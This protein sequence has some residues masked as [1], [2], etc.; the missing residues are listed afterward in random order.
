MYIPQILCILC[1]R[2]PFSISL[3]RFVL[4]RCQRS[5]HLALKFYWYLVSYVEDD[6]VNNTYVKT[7]K[8]SCEMALVN[9][10][11]EAS[12]ST[13]DL[14]NVANN[15]MER[16]A[17]FSRVTTLVDNLMRISNQLRSVLPVEE[18]PKALQ[19]KLSQTMQ[20]IEDNGAYI[21]LW[22]ADSR[23][24]SIV[25]LPPGEGVVLNSRDRCPYM[26]FFEVNISQLVCSQT[27]N[28][29]LKSEEIEVLIEKMKQK[30]DEDKLENNEEF[31]SDEEKQKAIE[32][33]VD[34]SP[35][36]PSQPQPE[37]WEE[38]KERIREKSPLAENNP[39]WDVK[40]L[41]VKYGDDCRQELLA[42]QLLSQMKRIFD[43]AALPIWLHPHSIL[44]VGKHSA[45]IEAIQN[46][47]SIHQIKKANANHSDLTSVFKLRYGEDT[48]KYQNSQRNFVESLAGYS[49]AS[50]IL[51][52]KDRHNGNLLLDNEGHIIHIDF[53]YM[54]GQSPGGISFE[55][56]PFKM[57]PEWLELMGGLD[58]D[59]FHYYKALM[60]KGF[61]ELIKYSDKIELLVE[62]MIYPKTGGKQ[63][64][65]CLQ[66][67]A[68][69]VLALK[70]RFEGLGKAEETV[71]SNVLNLI[72]KSISA[73]STG[74]YDQFQYFSNKIEYL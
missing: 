13:D 32:K 15:K 35:M 23:H 73:T 48:L 7:L 68:A 10:H 50:Y 4:H 26:L 5:M 71:V 11:D 57:V 22:G 38:R 45:L 59:L 27:S 67:G 37:S 62:M 55:S 52:F 18:R 17:Y 66:N 16:S 43:D 31:V 2:K 14:H 53:G 61:V 70:Q 20:N 3:E 72:N 58:G 6:N 42:V 34:A 54:L 65:S 8:E 69:A 49:I 25:R 9:G 44:V 47:K 41:I 74:L 19:E 36:K 51:Q 39:N 21:P 63:P 64:I 40:S 33:W 12:S 24:F 28:F 29:H 60:V 1:N 56:A 30:E 46:V